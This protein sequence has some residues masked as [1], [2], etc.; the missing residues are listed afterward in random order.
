MNTLPVTDPT[1]LVTRLV[2]GAIVL[3]VVFF[4]VRPEL[5]RRLWWARVDPRPV[6]LMRI[7]FGLVVLWTFVGLARDA[8]V[9]LTDEGMWL[10]DMAR[11]QF[12]GAFQHLWD[13]E[14]GFAHWWSPLLLPFGKFTIL[15]YWSAPSLVLALYALML[16]CLALMVLGVWTRW[17]TIL[18]WVLV[19]Q[20][21]R[22]QPLYH[23]GA[24]FVIQNFLFLGMLSRW[25]EAYSIDSWRRRSA[26]VPHGA[27]AAHRSIAAWP[28]RLMMLQLTLIY[29]ATGLTKS[30]QVWADGEALYYVLNLDH[31]Y[32]VPAQGLVTLLQYVGL[33]PL[34]TWVVRWWEVLFPAA[35]AGAVLRGYEA[36]RQAGCWPVAPIWRRRLSWLIGAGLWLL[37]CVTAGVLTGHY[38]TSG[39]I[40]LGSSRRQEQLV[41]AALLAIGPVVA[42][43]A[44]RFVRR[45]RPLV[46]EFLLCWVLGKRFWLG[47][48]VLLHLGINLG[49]NVGTF[50]EVMISVYF[51]WLS[52]P[53]IDALWRF[54]RSRRLWAGDSPRLVR[55]GW[56]RLL[57]PRK[58]GRRG[59][60]SAGQ[61]RAG[62]ST[63]RRI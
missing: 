40:P 55:P 57:Q 14:H 63:S 29:C 52:G 20:I 19:L 50:A 51:A 26:A 54:L 23:S 46:L 38:G 11:A 58:V 62:S 42:I 22:Y 16:G 61:Q 12:G 8:R 39:G 60:V 17:T 28:V 4:L 3:A 59:A 24:D 49:V 18:S 35:L 2:L 6:A 48:G 33:L 44:Y 41:V 27:P 37:L 25:G 53:E 43:P 31:F 32:R 10:P 9:F 5:W 36:D 21:Y 1:D 47:F 56:S 15:H 34:L 7:A 45:S 13:P 30:G